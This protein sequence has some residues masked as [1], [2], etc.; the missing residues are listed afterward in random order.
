GFSNLMDDSGLVT[1]PNSGGYALT[2]HG[3]GG[4]YDITY[5]CRL[6]ETVQ[7]DLALGST[8]TGHLIGSGQ[9]YLLRLGVPSSNPMRVV[10][11]GLS[12]GNNNEVYLRFG[13]PPTRGDFDFR[14][15]G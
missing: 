11:D 15:T 8:F 3:T 5:A 10:L 2:A 1:L 7:A 6:V 9:A 4:A 14:F 13:S 12:T